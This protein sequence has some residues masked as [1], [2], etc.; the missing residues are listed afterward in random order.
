MIALYLRSQIRVLK[1]SL[2]AIILIV[3]GLSSNVHAWECWLNRDLGVALQPTLTITG[4]GDPVEQNIDTCEI[5]MSNN[6]TTTI[7]F[8][9]TREVSSGISLY[10]GGGFLIESNTPNPGTLHSYDIS[11]AVQGSN[12]QGSIAFYF[13]KTPYYGYSKYALY[14]RLVSSESP[15]ITSSPVTTVEE[16][17]PYEYD[18]DATDPDAGDILTYSLDVSPAGMTIDSGTGLISWMPDSTHIGDNN[19]TVRVTDS[20]GLSDIQSFVVS[21]TPPESVLVVALSPDPNPETSTVMTGG[22]V[23]RYYRTEDDQGS[24]LPNAEAHLDCTA[25]GHQ[26]QIFTSDDDGL[27]TIELTVDDLGNAG[28]SPTCIFQEEPSPSFDLTITPRQSTGGYKFGSGINAA[29]AIGFGLSAGKKNGLAYI[30]QNPSGGIEI[31]RSKERSVGVSVGAGIGAGIE[32]LA[33]VGADATVGLEV[34]LSYMNKYQFTDPNEETQQILRSGLILASLFESVNPVVDLLLTFV[35]DAYNPFYEQYKTEAQYSLGLNLKAGAE[36]KLSLGAEEEHLGMELGGEIS[37]AIQLGLNLTR[38]YSQ[39]PLRAMNLTGTGMGMSYGVEANLFYGIEGNLAD[40]PYT[41]LNFGL[42][43]G[44]ASKFE[45]NL[46][47]D[48]QA[49]QVDLL[50]LTFSAL[51]QWGIGLQ[52]AANANEG[53][54]LTISFLLDRDQL[55][56]LAPEIASL[57]SALSYLN[58]ST[59]GT[60]MVGPTILQA[61]FLKLFVLLSD[62]DFAYEITEEK[63]TAF[64]FEPTLK[65][66]LGFKVEAGFSVSAEKSVTI[67]KEKGKILPGHLDYYPLESYEFDSNVL[68]PANLSFLDVI[69][70]AGQGVWTAALAAGRLH[71]AAQRALNETLVEA[72]NWAFSDEESRSMNQS[73]AG[74]FSNALF[75]RSGETGLLHDPATNFGLVGVYT[76][77]PVD[78]LIIDLSRD[79]PGDEIIVTDDGTLSLTISPNQAAA[80]MT[81]T[82]DEAGLSGVDENNLLLYR[83]YEMN[84]EWTVVPDSRVDTAGNTVTGSIDQLGTFTLGLPF[85]QGEIKLTLSPK[86]ADIANPGTISVIAGPVLMSTGQ[87]VPDGTLFTVSS[88]KRYGSPGETFGTINGLGTNGARAGIPLST[89]NGLLSFNITPPAEIGSG[90]V[91]IQAGTGTARGSA[92]FTVT[93][94]DQDQNG[95]P[96]YWE[97]ARF[98]ATGMDPLADPDQDN[99]TNIEEYENETN[100]L[101]S[102]SDDDLMPD[103]WEVDNNLNPNFNDSG[104]DPDRDRF[105]N[106]E[107]L[108][109]NTNPRQSD[110]ADSPDDSGTQPGLVVT[111]GG[112]FVSSL[113]GE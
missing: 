55:T 92:V 31:E 40:S 83:W 110:L 21:V 85:P 52:G 15:S 91:Q 94:L 43:G 1:I 28:D 99:L 22:T 32:D 90:L 44:G 64:S 84:R 24:A 35:L 47:Y 109:N 82:Y 89:V 63:G 36:A 105:T 74:D 61:E 103:K 17:T 46:H 97:N 66:K 34:V 8:V 71:M 19:I 80:E 38:E 20:Y 3:F 29:A 78:K 5:T 23:Y 95:L 73:R 11:A 57:L 77:T 58:F 81:F 107:E 68:D 4:G 79:L 60:I 50:K 51:K 53:S 93:D 87:T 70:D 75:T 76:L 62:M 100:P 42:G 18:A 26:T 54:T 12:R 67:L 39:A 96:D 48:Q 30:L 113:N 9:T 56:I 2:A 6:A 7:S 37:G 25:P 13:T 112:C 49:G 33:D 72:W 101:K 41:R 59:P 86:D 106:L 98:G 14:V 88:L 45:M 69:E 27:L 108:N 102:D 10:G 111:G 104:L 16:N 65:L